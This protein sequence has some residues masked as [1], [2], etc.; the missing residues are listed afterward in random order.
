MK[1]P[2]ISLSEQVKKSISHK[3]FVKQFGWHFVDSHEPRRKKA[4]DTAYE[5]LT[6]R[7]ATKDEATGFKNDIDKA[8]GN[9]SGSNAAAATGE[10]KG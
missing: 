10:L 2:K 1:Q 6:G 3:D 7:K 5:T 8:K 9:D 4:I